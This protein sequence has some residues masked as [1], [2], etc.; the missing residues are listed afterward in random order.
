MLRLAG[1]ESDSRLEREPG[2]VE[3][4]CLLERDAEI[5][6][7]RRE[8][9][10]ERDGAPIGCERLLVTAEPA[11]GTRRDRYGRPRAPGPS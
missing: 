11:A 6:V 10:I 4:A 2:L 9:R 8:A 5:M 3:L 7:R 1:L